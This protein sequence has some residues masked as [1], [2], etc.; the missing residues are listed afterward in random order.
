MRLVR[1]TGPYNYVEIGSFRGGSLSPFLMDPA[2]KNILSIDDRG[3]VQ[4]D[5]RGISI[6]YTGMTTQSMLDELHRNNMNT[7]KLRT[8]DGAVNELDDTNT[9]SFDLAFIDGEHTDEACF[10]DF[11]WTFPLMKSNSI[12]SF[13]DSGLIYKSLKIAMLYL[14]KVNV[15]YTFFKRDA[16]NMSAFI[17]G[18]YRASDLIAYLGKEEDEVAFFAKSEADRIEA[19]CYNRARVHFAPSKILKLQ[20]PLAVEIR[21]PRPRAPLDFGPSRN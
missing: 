4:S 9:D 5:E 6:D 16:S 2:C 8:F 19:Q 12:I 3:R 20:F 18:E 1:N 11:I 7:D 13:H 21:R 17:F 10:R 14:D 15:G